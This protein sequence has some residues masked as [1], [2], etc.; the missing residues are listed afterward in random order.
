MQQIFK[1]ILTIG[2][3]IVIVLAV[4]ALAFTVYRVPCGSLLREGDRVVV[5][6]VARTE[7]RKHDL[8]LAGDSS[9]LFIGSIEALP[10]DTIRVGKDRYVIP[11][12]CCRRCKCPYCHTYMLYLGGRNYTLVQKHQIKG[13]AYKLFHLPF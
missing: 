13:K 2:A 5:D 7:F 6:R 3:A 9:C 12:K 4:R 1:W 10:G 11:T 8:I